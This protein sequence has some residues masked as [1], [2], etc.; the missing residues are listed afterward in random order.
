MAEIDGM[1]TEPL[2]QMLSAIPGMSYP[3][4][5]ALIGTGGGLAYAFTMKP[6]VSFDAQ[7]NA[8]P[9]AFTDSE[10]GTYWP[11]WMWGVAPG[12]VLGVLL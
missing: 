7:G 5:R 11:W 6:S 9:W 10:N 4:T 8:R 12:F 2:E 1:V 3:F